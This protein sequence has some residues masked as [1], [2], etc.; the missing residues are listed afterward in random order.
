MYPASL[1]AGAYAGMTHYL[2]AVKQMG[3]ATAKLSGARTVAVM[4]QIPTDDDAFG[5]GR[6]REDGQMIAPV[7]LLQVKP[8]AERVPLGAAFRVVATTPAADAFRPLSE[9]GCPMI[10]S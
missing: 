3:V 9:G 2:K 10:R 5:P 6:V 7:F 8:E 1:H 4:K